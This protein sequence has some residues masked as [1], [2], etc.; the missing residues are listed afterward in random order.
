MALTYTRLHL[1]LLLPLAALAL[2]PPRPLHSEPQQIRQVG[3]R[4]PWILAAIA[5]VFSCSWDSLIAWKGVWVVEADMVV[6]SAAF[7]PFEECLWFV[8]HT[9]LASVWVLVLWSRKRTGARPSAL[10]HWPARVVG[11]ALCLLVTTLGLQLLRADQTFYL[12]VVLTFMS[13]IVGFHWWMGGHLLL[14]QPREW[15]LGIAVP[16]AYLLLL[17]TWAMREGVWRL[18]EEYVTGVRAVGLPIEHLLL[19][20]VTTAL[21][22]LPLVASLRAAEPQFLERDQVT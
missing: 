3:Y 4:M 14:Q 18:S 1:F 8:D 5:F 22:V 15:M 12:G 7:M 19:Y 17:D 13:P 11:A 16:S 21:V 10:P 6:G 20:T 9:L 2:V